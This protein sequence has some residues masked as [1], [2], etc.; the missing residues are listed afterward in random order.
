VQLGELGAEIVG[1]HRLVTFQI[2]TIVLNGS[3]NVADDISAFA[4][5]LMAAVDGR[6]M[7]VASGKAGT[8]RPPA[9]KTR[10]VANR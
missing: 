9:S 4:Q 7:P 8:A 6:S 3:D 2:D 10:A 1:G 5:V